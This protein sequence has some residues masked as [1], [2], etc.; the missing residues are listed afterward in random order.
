MPK[1]EVTKEDLAIL[2]KTAQTL[3]LAKEAV[4]IGDKQKEL[5][6]CMQ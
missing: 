2:N 5:F 6:N 3:N 4:D 1:I